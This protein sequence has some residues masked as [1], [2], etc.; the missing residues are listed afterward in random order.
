MQYRRF[1]AIEPKSCSVIVPNAEPIGTVIVMM[2]AGL[3]CNGLPGR[4]FQGF[5]KYEV[6]NGDIYIYIYKLED[7]GVRI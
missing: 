2:I 4:K 3:F 6:R 7:Y 1:F 5:T